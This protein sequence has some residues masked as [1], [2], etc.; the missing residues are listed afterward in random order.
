MH[1]CVP[2]MRVHAALGLRATNPSPIRFAK[3]LTR[4]IGCVFYLFVLPQACDQDP[5]HAYAKYGAFS[6]SKLGYSW[7]AETA[8]KCG[9]PASTVKA[10][11][12]PVWTCD[13]ALVHFSKLY[14]TR[15]GAG[16]CARTSVSKVDQT[17]NT[18]DD[19][20]HS[21][22]SCNTTE[23]AATISDMT[24]QTMVCLKTGFQ[25]SIL[26]VSLCT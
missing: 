15:V 11:P 20:E 13:G 14:P 3:S 9:H 22:A 1:E 2:R 23:C 10:T 25:V 16:A 4:R 17:G 18:Y 6:T 19:Y 8:S 12:P 21:Q 7:L 5:N 26:A 24:D